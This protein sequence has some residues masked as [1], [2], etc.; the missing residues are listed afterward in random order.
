[1]CTSVVDQRICPPSSWR[2]S[3]HH[4]QPSPMLD[5]GMSRRWCRWH[6]MWRFFLI[7]MEWMRVSPSGRFPS[8]RDRAGGSRTDGRLALVS[9]HYMMSLSS[10]C[11]M[12]RPVSHL[13]ERPCIPLALTC[14]PEGH[15][16]GSQRLVLRRIPTATLTASLSSLNPHVVSGRA[17]YYLFFF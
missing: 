7:A 8:V 17:Y 5:G 1:M 6:P 16:C 10:W 13:H 3:L 14:L 15:W 4:H 9:S 11:R 12:D 2:R